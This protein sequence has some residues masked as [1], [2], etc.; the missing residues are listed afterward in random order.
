[1]SVFGE[2]KQICIIFMFAFLFVAIRM[3]F[4]KYLNG[5]SKFNGILVEVLVLALI[6][7]FLTN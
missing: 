1:M 4:G 5:E 2:R 7:K 6:L 3:N